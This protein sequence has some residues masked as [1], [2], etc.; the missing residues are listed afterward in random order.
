MVMYAMDH[1]DTF[2]A[3]GSIAKLSGTGQT[4]ANAAQPALLRASLRLY[5]DDS[6]WFC[7]ADPVQGK[8]VL[9]LGID[10]GL[11]SYAIPAI[12]EKDGNPARV[13]KVPADTVL[14][15]DA[16]G[17]RNSCDT[18]VWFAGKA[19]WA[20]NHPNGEVNYVMADLSLHRTSAEALSQAKAGGSR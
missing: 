9:Y 10:H 6:N 15:S 13:S 18:G 4:P 1:D 20:S 19:D 7:P 11:M 3:Y 2:P 5:T 14:A 16:A 12:R 17:D 8:N